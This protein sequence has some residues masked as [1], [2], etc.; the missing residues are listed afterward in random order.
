MK[1]SS[2]PWVLVPGLGVFFFVGVLLALNGY[3]LTALLTVEGPA[4]GLAVLAA[5]L[6]LVSLV[7]GIRRWAR[8]GHET[9]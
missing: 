3:F 1:L 5:I 6:W 2:L 7:D 4:V 8:K 9:R